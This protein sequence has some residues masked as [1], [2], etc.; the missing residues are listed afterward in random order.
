MPACSA[1]LLSAEYKDCRPMFEGMLAAIGGTGGKH[2]R[3]RGEDDQSQVQ[4]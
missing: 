4:G 2:G 1:R 3:R